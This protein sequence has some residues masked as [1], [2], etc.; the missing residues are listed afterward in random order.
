MDTSRPTGPSRTPLAS[1][2][3]LLV[4]SAPPPPRRMEPSEAPPEPVER[5]TACM[6]TQILQK[7]AEV[8]G[9]ALQ[10]TAPR[11]KNTCEPVEKG[12]NSG[13][14]SLL[15]RPLGTGVQSGW[16]S[17]QRAEYKRLIA[18]QAARRV[19]EIDGLRRGAELALRE[20]RPH[21]AAMLLD[22]ARQVAR[23]AHAERNLIRRAV[24]QRMSPAGRTTSKAIEVDRSWGAL[25]QKYG[26]DHKNFD[27][28]RTIAH[29]SGTSSPGA[30]RLAAVGGVLA[31]GA[32]VKGVSDAVREVQAVPLEQKP[33]V[34]IQ[35]GVQAAGGA[36]GANLGAM[37]VRGLAVAVG[38]GSGGLGLGAAIVAGSAIGGWAGGVVARGLVPGKEEP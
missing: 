25:V 9:Q 15:P 21:E 10:S 32:V 27:L 24:Q 20:N 14:D 23:E 2:P 29:K 17:L 28:Y 35:Q 36:I 12:R 18:E 26:K 4:C 30:T 6:S 5:V 7:R 19:G 22:K 8:A 33:G 38:A 37:A 1:Y 31:A 34:I 13:W 11:E 16:D 3:E